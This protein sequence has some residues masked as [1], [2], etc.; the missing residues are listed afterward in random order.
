MK[1]ANHLCKYSAAT[2][3]C[4]SGMPTHKLLLC[5]CVPLCCT[6]IWFALSAIWMWW[7]SVAG[8]GRALRWL[9]TAGLAGA[10]YMTY[11]SMHDGTS[12]PA[13]SSWQW[14]CAGHLAGWLMKGNGKRKCKKLE[15]FLANGLMLHFIQLWDGAAGSQ[16]SC[17]NQCRSSLTINAPLIIL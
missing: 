7:Q 3:A 17:L 12:H 9:L 5:Y 14:L 8:G 4:V 11:C 13:L 1:P 6:G 16:C 10:Y 2:Y 15:S